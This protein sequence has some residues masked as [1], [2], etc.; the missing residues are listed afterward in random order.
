MEK[1][2]VYATKIE[3]RKDVRLEAKD[4]EVASEARCAS[5]VQSNRVGTP[6][7]TKGSWEGP[8]LRI[9]RPTNSTGDC[10]IWASL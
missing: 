2:V 4:H 8:Q 9:G 7:L 3:G 5:V 10:L 6:T 1:I